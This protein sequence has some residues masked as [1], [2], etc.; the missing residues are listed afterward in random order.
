MFLYLENPDKSKT[1]FLKLINKF[2][3]VVGY[4]INAHKSV[5][6]LYTRN[7][8]TEETLKKKKIPFSIAAKKIQYLGIN[9]TKVVKDLY[10]ENYITLIKE[11][12]RNSKKIEKYSLFMDRKAKCH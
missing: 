4:K 11:I 6:F 2:S 1:Q 8:L 10:I 5:M 7:N 9:L 12:E 3:K